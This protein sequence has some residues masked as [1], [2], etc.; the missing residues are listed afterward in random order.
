MSLRRLCLLAVFLWFAPSA[1]PSWSA[2]QSF[3]G[4]DWFPPP[5]SS[6]TTPAYG[7]FLIDASAEKVGFVINIT[8]TCTL[9]KAE[10][11]LGTVTQAPANG[12]RIDRK[13]TRLNSSH[14]QKSRMPSSA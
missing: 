4:G 7:A 14:I 8:R 3:G 2:M 12:L 5:L 11:R 1:T 9:D 6:N 10:F 13:S